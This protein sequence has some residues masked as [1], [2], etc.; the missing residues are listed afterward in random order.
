MGIAEAAPESESAPAVAAPESE[1]VAFAEAAFA[2]T[3]ESESAPIIDSSP[4]AVTPP[5]ETPAE[6]AMSTEVLNTTTE[7]PPPAVII[8]AK[9]EDKLE[10]EKE[11]AELKAADETTEEK[12]PGKDAKTKVKEAFDNIHMP[13]MPKLHKPA[14]LKKKK[15]D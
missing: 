13:K 6:K 11:E 12:P 3:P 5:P 15:T 2:S 4:E 14:F 8:S 1:P 9:S 10:I 7:A